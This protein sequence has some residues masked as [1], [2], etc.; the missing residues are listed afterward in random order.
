MAIFKFRARHAKTGKPIKAQVSLG[1][2]LRG[3]T[4]DIKDSWL[5][6]ETS[7]SD[8]YTWYA[9]YDG[10]KIGYG[11]SSGGEIEIVYSPE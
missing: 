10:S 5:I 11:T 2:T 3:Y 1:G 7:Q 4:P 6:V 9:K 8:K